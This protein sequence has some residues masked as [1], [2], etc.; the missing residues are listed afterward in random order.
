MMKRKGMLD[1]HLRNI[2]FKI[3]EVKA[4]SKQ[5][6]DGRWREAAGAKIMKNKGREGRRKQENTAGNVLFIPSTSFIQQ[7]VSNMLRM[8]RKYKV[9]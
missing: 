8:P 9:N 4:F 6:E 3:E 7:V 2:T 1:R 5:N